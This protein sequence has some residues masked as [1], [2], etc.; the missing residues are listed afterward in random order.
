MNET[1]YVL[2]TGEA[3][4]P[5]EIAPGKDGRL[6]HKDGR[7]VAYAPHGPR[8]RSVDPDA[9]RAKSVKAGKSSV[10]QAREAKAMP[11]LEEPDAAP[12]ETRDLK[13]DEPK[14]GYKTRESKAD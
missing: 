9:E 5:R 1:W 6:E 7:K 14:R 3:G 8:S 13:A 2:E 12:T 10:N 11:P 4:D